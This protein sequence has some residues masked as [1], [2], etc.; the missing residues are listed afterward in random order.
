MTA[1]PSPAVASPK[2]EMRAVAK[3]FGGNRVLRGVNL[4][5][6]PGSSMVV[7]V[8][9][10]AV[11]DCVQERDVGFR[12]ERNTAIGVARLLEVEGRF[13]H[14][15]QVAPPRMRACFGAARGNYI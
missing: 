5:V 13:K 10:F 15:A 14:V 11:H 6:A 4:S 7:I 3:A 1:A 2:I 12:T 8:A 9:P